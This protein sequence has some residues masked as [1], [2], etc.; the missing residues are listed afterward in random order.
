MKE[1]GEPY[2]PRPGLS[3]HIWY[4]LLEVSALQRAGLLPLLSPRLA[5]REVF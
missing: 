3:I 2:R 5:V 4:C 1:H